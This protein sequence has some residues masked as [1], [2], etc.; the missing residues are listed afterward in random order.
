MNLELIHTNIVNVSA[1]AIVLPANTML[2]EA[3]LPLL[4]LKLPD[5]ENSPRHVRRLDHARWEAR[6]RHWHLI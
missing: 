3:V 1:D 5:A 2:K 4:F 6:F